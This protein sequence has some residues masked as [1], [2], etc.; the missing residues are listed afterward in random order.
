MTPPTPPG[1]TP[2]IRR[3]LRLLDGYEQ[4]FPEEAATIARFRR[5]AEKPDAFF[6]TCRPGHFTASALV[7]D[8]SRRRVLLVKHRKLGIWVQPGGHADGEPDLLSAAV[9]E[10]EEETGLAGCGSDGAV[11]DLDIH[12]I[13]ARPGEGAHDHYDVRFLLIG[14][15]SRPLIVSDE[16]DDVRWISVGDLPIYTEEESMRRL[17]RKAGAPPPI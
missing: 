9:R 12:P 14:D 6:R 7:V 16:S 1:R 5:L 11:L 4:T 10:T 13:P 8:E 17:L 15:P 2:G 3:F